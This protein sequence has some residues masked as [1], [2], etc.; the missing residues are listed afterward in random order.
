MQRWCKRA[1]GRW[2]QENRSSH[3]AA[4]GPVEA[5]DI[6]LHRIAARWMGAL[7]W[8]GSDLGEA[9][10]SVSWFFIPRHLQRGWRRRCEDKHTPL[11][12]ILSAG[13][14]PGLESPARILAQ[15]SSSPLTR[16]GTVE[17]WSFGVDGRAGG[18]SERTSL[19]MLSLLNRLAVCSRSIVLREAG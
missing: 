19:L 15:S 11:Q 9:A 6:V 2:K 8:I 5:G 1:T 4:V 14:Q 7:S 18:S 16:T 12:K 3:A 17:H 13:T 10:Q